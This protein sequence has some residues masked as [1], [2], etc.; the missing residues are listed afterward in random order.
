MSQ[1]YFVETPISE[2]RV[3]L[4][5][6]EAHHLIH[7]MRARPGARV[8]LFDGS[9]LEFAARLTRVGRTR[10][11][12]EIVSRSRADRELPVQLELAVALPKADRRRWL[13]EKATELGVR[14]IIPLRTNRSMAQPAQQA[15]QRLHRAVIEASKQCGR[16][17]LM[18]ITEPRDWSDFVAETRAQPCRLLADAH[19]TDPPAKLPLEQPA[20]RILMAVG[21]EGGLTADEVALATAA[22]WRPLGLGPRVLRVETAAILLTA[23]VLLWSELGP[24]PP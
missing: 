1:R 5:G 18:Q 23:A 4:R 10:V 24:K 2:D 17:V 9:G 22:G 3:V 19:C 16:N 7:V 6:A 11:E 20:E 12:L 15:L 13:V 14:R 21:P 8:V